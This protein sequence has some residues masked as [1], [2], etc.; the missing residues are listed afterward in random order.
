MGEIE[1][2]LNN[3]KIVLHNGIKLKKLSE[4]VGNLNI[5]IFTPNDINILREGP[6]ERRKFLD[7]MIGQLKPR[8]LYN[9]SMYNKTLE[10]RNSF[11]KNKVENDEMLEI[12]DEKLYEYGKIINNYRNDFI[13]KI[14][15]KIQSIHDKIT[16]EIIEIEYL[17]DCDN[18][19]NFIKKLKSKRAIDKIRGYTSAGVHR[20]DFKIYIDKK[21]VNIYGSQGQN[22]TAV[23]S[24]KL[25]EIEIIKDDIGEYPILLLDDFMSELDEKRI[26]NFL[27][28]I[29]NIQVII[30]CT[31]NIEIENSTSYNIQNGNIIA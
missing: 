8:Y 12:W 19:E 11:L 3:K 29:K 27:T 1:I 26:K 10:Q 24:L 14:S 9:L 13:K 16:K 4:L 18:K 31:K 20:D 17:S 6:A 28:N 2:L 5:V 23:L 22:R 25:S 15:Q 30:T 21:E 7:M